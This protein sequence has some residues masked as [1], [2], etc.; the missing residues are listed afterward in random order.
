MARG[1]SSGSMATLNGGVNG[2][3][4]TLSGL[5]PMW[6]QARSLSR[7][8]AVGLKRRVASY[9]SMTK[10]RRASTPPSLVAV[11]RCVMLSRTSNTQPPHLTYGAARLELLY[12]CSYTAICVLVSETFRSPHFKL[13]YRASARAR[14]HCLPLLYS[15]IQ[16]MGFE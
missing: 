12:M 8:M 11:T 10:L 14:C 6:M 16:Y 5:P 7:K 4:E 3:L 1:V 9:L 13:A 15:V 2:R